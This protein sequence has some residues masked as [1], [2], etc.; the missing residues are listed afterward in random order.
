MEEV[1]RTSVRRLS[2]V[3]LLTST[4]HNI[5]KKDIHLYPYRLQA[6][7]QLLEADYLVRVEY[8]N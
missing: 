7:Q 8:C 4:S 5:L 3:Q 6:V 1:Q 2:R